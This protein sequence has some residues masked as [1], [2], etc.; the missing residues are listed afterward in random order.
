M[1]H[2]IDSF[3]ASPPL[4]LRLLSEFGPHLHLV[5]S[6][7]LKPGGT[8][9]CQF[10]EFYLQVSTPSSNTETLWWV[11]LTLPEEELW[12]WW[13]EIP[14]ISSYW[15]FSLFY[16]KYLFMLSQLGAWPDVKPRCLKLARWASGWLHVSTLSHL[17]D[18][19]RDFSRF[20]S[21]YYLCK[22]GVVIVFFLYVILSDTKGL[23]K[24]CT[25]VGHFCVFIAK[26]QNYMTS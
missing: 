25:V 23:R 26:A 12:T 7:T 21:E 9:T 8:G 17:L 2:W 22:L 6:W 24:Y 15:I 13:F 1:T 18:I 20:I 14:T 3:I 16:S 19:W 5:I 4:A 10:C 11:K